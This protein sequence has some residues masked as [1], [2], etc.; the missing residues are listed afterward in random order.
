MITTSR[1]IIVFFDQYINAANNAG[2]SIF[3]LT[4]SKDLV[5]IGLHL[6]QTGPLYD[7]KKFCPIKR[8]VP[9]LC[10]Y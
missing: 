8:G 1:H 9:F 6:S 7:V 4:D 3:L 10:H 2:V 5:K